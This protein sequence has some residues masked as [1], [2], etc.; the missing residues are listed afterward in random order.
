MRPICDA[1]ITCELAFSMFFV[2]VRNFLFGPK[3]Q[4]ASEVAHLQKAAA[5]SGLDRTHLLDG[6]IHLLHAITE[7][8]DKAGSLQMQKTLRVW[9]L[10][11]RF[12]IEPY[13]NFSSK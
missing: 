3:S 1:E 8:V 6:Q 10:V 9:R 4:L 12:D 7:F 2:N 13:F 11:E 5:W